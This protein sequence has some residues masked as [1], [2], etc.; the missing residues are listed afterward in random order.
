[1]N[2]ASALP[3]LAALGKKGIP[4]PPDL[5]DMTSD[6]EALPDNPSV[7]PAAAPDVSPDMSIG[8]AP[9]TT[10]P[11]PA[12]PLDTLTR[13]PGGEGANGVPKLAGE[14]KGHKLLR[15]L[16]GA[17]YGTAAGAGQRTFGAGFQQAQELPLG[18]EHQQLQ[19]EQVRQMLPFLRAQQ[20]AGLQK[21][22][23]DVQKTQAEVEGMPI[24]QALERAQTEAANYKDD[25]NLGLIDIRTKQPVNPSGFAPLSADEAAV[26]GKQ[27]G[28]RVPLKLK[29]TAN[30]I[31]MRG[32]TNVQTEEGVFE[33]N[34]QTG[35]MTRL[36]S[37]PRMMFAPDQRIIPVSADPNNPGA[38]TF[39][40]AGQA[41]NT[42]AQAP[43]SAATTAA[44]TEA[45]SEVPTKI[46]DQKV[47]FNTM[48]QH[49]Q[50]LRQ[51]AKDLNN[52]D[53]Q[54]LNGLKNSFANAF[55]YSGPITAQA[56][57]DA[58]KGEVSNVINKGHITDTGN[59]KVEHTLDP[60][61]QN[62]ATLDSVIGAYQALAQ[63]KLNML[64][65]Q[66][67]IAKGQKGN[68]ARPTHRWNPQTQRIEAIQ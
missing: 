15:I 61:H 56:I 34:R 21:T 48:I 20:I 38:I 1:M 35:K 18:I 44:K 32:I 11:P 42:G 14:T 30:E 66:A 13:F 65:Q 54:A 36:G 63:S 6:Y 2:I 26:L 24:K 39:M 9:Q 57:A 60:T 59:E 58:Y 41:M 3:F 7:T 68:E 5:S 4:P 27:P 43:T 28:D 53:V 62:Y 16:L 31:A 45:R 22:Q 55:G 17:G 19:N 37:N 10:P 25:P 33:R 64:N 49:A 46:G 67:N 51:A 52:G 29:N 23:A 50:L 40:R 12:N 47:A 8:A